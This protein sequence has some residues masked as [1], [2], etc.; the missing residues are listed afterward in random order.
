MRV[1]VPPPPIFQLCRI[2]RSAESVMTVVLYSV[3]RLYNAVT[4]R[5]SKRRMWNARPAWE[6]ASR[7]AGKTLFAW[8]AVPL[9]TA[10][11]RYGRTFHRL[12]RGQRIK[13]RPMPQKYLRVTMPDNSQWD[14]PCEVIAAARATCWAISRDARRCGIGNTITR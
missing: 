2:Y 4:A 5:P 9:L 10:L 11:G 12:R 8:S 13:K 14:I 6:R 1:R 3:T 7:H